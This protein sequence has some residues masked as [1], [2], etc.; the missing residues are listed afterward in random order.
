VQA[1]LEKPPLAA[2]NYASNDPVNRVDPNGM[3]SIPG[4][5]QLAVTCASAAVMNGAVGSTNVARYCNMVR[6]ERNWAYRWTE[7]VFGNDADNYPSNAFRHAYGMA[8]ITY[9]GADFLDIG[10]EVNNARR[11][12]TAIGNRVEAI[13]F[14]ECV[15]DPANTVTYCRRAR[16]MDQH[17]NSIG[18]KVGARLSGYCKAEKRAGWITYCIVELMKRRKL[19]V[20]FWPGHTDKNQRPRRTFPFDVPEPCR[21]N[22]WACG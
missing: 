10:N 20:L 1:L 3:A 5:A 6:K 13:G 14:P 11:A 12:A 4:W 15:A 21:S 8:R 2:N 17:N 9:F 18:R 16:S 22:P 19:K 7:K